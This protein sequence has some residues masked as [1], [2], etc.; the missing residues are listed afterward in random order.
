[1]S[2][3]VGGTV[4]RA[5]KAVLAHGSSYFHAELSKN[6]GTMTHVTLDHVEDSVFQHLLGF[7][8]TSE[9]VVAETDLPALADAARFLDMMDVLKLLCEDGKATSS[10]GETRET[11]LEIPSCDAAGADTEVQSTLTSKISPQHSVAE[12]TNPA[13]GREVKTCPKSATTR[14]STCTR[15]TPS[16]HKKDNGNHCISNPME[17][18]RVESSG[19]P[20]EHKV[21]GVLEVNRDVRETPKPSQGDDVMEED[22]EEDQQ[23]VD[24]GAVSQK[25]I[26]EASGN[27]RTALE[28]GSHT[29]RM[30]APSG[31]DREV[32]MPPAASTNQSPEYPEGLAPVIIQTSSKKT[33]KCP[34]CEKTFD[35]A[36][37]FPRSRI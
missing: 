11:E 24:T 33:L 27:D 32:Y 10:Q 17:Q 21:D 14:R 4:Y 8:Y 22:A 26:C 19:R 37:W 35:R 1:M 12:S 31:Q 15:K 36:G 2:V 25:N 6:S 28:E 3:L 5:H 30:E 9:C 13:S 18:Q 34:K 7:L 16:K 20:D 29:D 23:D